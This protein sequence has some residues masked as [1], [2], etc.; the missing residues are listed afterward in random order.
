MASSDLSCI[1]SGLR[2][3]KDRAHEK[4]SAACLRPDARHREPD[5]FEFRGEQLCLL[6]GE[7]DQRRPHPRPRRIVRVNRDRLLQRAIIDGNF[8]LPNTSRTTFSFRL[9]ILADRA[10]AAAYRHR[11]RRKLTFVQ[12]V[13]RG[14]VHVGRRGNRAHTA[15]AHVGE[16]ERFAADK[17]V[18]PS[19]AGRAVAANASRKV[20]VLFQS[21]ELSFIP[22]IAFG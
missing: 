8:L 20:L 16:Q 4:F 15:V 5:R 18:E 22:A 1:V 12:L 6:C 11:L 2:S 17:H 13:N 9:L 19:R 7:L 3:V 14:R 21:P 10:S